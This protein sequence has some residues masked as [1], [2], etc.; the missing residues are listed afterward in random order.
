MPTGV[1]EIGIA[2]GGVSLL[3]GFASAVDGYHLLC[4]IFAKDNG[5]RSLATNL[6][7]EKVGFKRWGEHVRANEPECLLHTESELVHGAVG[8]VIAEIMSLQ[9]QTIPKLEKYDIEDLKVPAVEGPSDKA[10]EGSKW[11][12][13][14][15]EHWDKIKQVSGVRWHNLVECV[16][17][18]DPHFLPISTH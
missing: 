16:L 7:V 4:D 15:Q 13:K 9:Q 11:A 18:T 10:K 12:K 2:L 5:L 8:V 17:W 6:H 14:I 1:E 3:A